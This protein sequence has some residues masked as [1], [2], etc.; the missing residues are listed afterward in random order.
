M[1]PAVLFLQ[2]TVRFRRGFSAALLTLFLLFL[3]GGLLSLLLSALF[4]EASAFLAQLPALLDVLPTQTAGLLARLQEYGALC[5]VWIQEL[6]ADAL[7]DWT[8]Y[9]GASCAS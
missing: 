4:A 2:R 9:G 6:L 3:L 1:E 8:D 5:P 7:T